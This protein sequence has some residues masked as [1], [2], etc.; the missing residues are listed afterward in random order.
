MPGSMLALAIGSVLSRRLSLALTV[1][2][3][4]L[5]VALFLSVERLRIAA[6]DSFDGT[7]SG[8]DVLVGARGGELGLLLYTVFQIGDAAPS[9]RWSSF[10]DLAEDDRVEWSVPISLGDSHRGYRVVATTSNFFDHVKT[11]RD[12]AAAL[13]RVIRRADR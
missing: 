10:E 12:R 9:M 2:T 6:R 11:G 13:R 7:I 8:V 3:M 1:L 4:A 5:S